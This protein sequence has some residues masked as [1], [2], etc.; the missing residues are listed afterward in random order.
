MALFSWAERELHAGFAR[1]DEAEFGAVAQ[2]LAFPIKLALTEKE[3]VM[4]IEIELHDSVAAELAYIVELHKEHGA[5]NAQDSV[6]AL[7]AYVASAI[8]AGS[9]R[10]G[11]WERTCLDMMGLVANTDEHHYYRSDYGRPEA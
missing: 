10:P 9:R 3:R 6:E 11:A 4:K 7:L 1:A 8:A 2:E 5:A